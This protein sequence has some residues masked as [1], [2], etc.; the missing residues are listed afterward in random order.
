MADTNYFSAIVKVL[1]N[2][3]QISLNN[4]FLVTKFL[5]EVPQIRKPKAITLYF[6][7]KLGI[8][9]KNYYQKN[10]YILV[11]GYISKHNKTSYKSDFKVSKPITLIVLKVYPILL[12]TTKIIDQ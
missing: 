9:S 3:K 6:W 5:A 2:S 10:D 12:N 7:G 8:E 4:N 11:E 1:K